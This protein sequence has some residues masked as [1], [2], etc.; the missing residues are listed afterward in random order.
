MLASKFSALY[1]VDSH[2]LEQEKSS[3]W[4]MVDNGVPQGSVLEPLLFIIYLNDLPCGLHQGAK[5]V[6]Y[7]DDTSV[8]LMA[9]N[10]EELKKQN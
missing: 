2:I 9:K 5:P 1:H 10:D 3:N 4:E 7:A 8:L 6:I